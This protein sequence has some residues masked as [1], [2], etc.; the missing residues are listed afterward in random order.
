MEQN[1]EKQAKQTHVTGEGQVLKCPVCDGDEFIQRLSVVDRSISR[2][3]FTVRSCRQCGFCHT[4][5][6]PDEHSI[7]RYY[8]SD[9][10]ISHSESRKGIINKLYGFLQKSNLRYK[11]RLVSKVVPR[12]TWLDYGA[13]AGAFMHYCKGQGTDIMGLEP[14]EPSRKKAA[15]KGLEIYPPSHIASLS[16]NTYAAITMWHVLEHVHK[17]HGLL[18]QAGRVLKPDGLLII[19]VPNQLSYDAH[20]Y[21]EFWAAYDV[22]RHLWHFR[23]KDVQSLTEPHGFQFLSK[24]PL[25]LDA[26]YVSM[27]SEKYM[28]GMLLRGIWIGLRSNFHARFS[29]YPYSSEVYVFKKTQRLKTIPDRG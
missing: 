21:K 2:E 1:T 4:H 29:G 23:E 14:N 8:A 26:F 24:H 13:G 16:E 27:L 10:Y 15:E 19:A 3:K 22:P 12:G 7:G 6:Q 25:K 9:E 28:K 20:H 11:H 18:D 5:P 17:L